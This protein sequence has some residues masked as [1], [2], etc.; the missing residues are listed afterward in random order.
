LTHYDPLASTQSEVHTGI[1]HGEGKATERLCACGC[2]RYARVGEYNSDCRTECRCGCGGRARYAYAPGHNPQID[3][4]RCGKKFTPRGTKHEQKCSQC[5]R[6]VRSGGPKERNSRLAHNREQQ[7]KAPEGKRW[8]AGCERY[9]AIKFFGQ[10]REKGVQKRYSRC[11]P[12]FREQGRASML[13]KKYNITAAEY[14][15]IKDFQGGKCAICQKAT[16]ASR[17]LAVD[18][19]HSCC[20]S[21]GSCGKC[22]RGTLCSTCNKLLGFARDDISMFI[23]AID[24]LNYPPAKVVLRNDRT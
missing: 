18:H 13:T 1:D 15:A 21:G 24:Y 16:G 6:H 5:R 9:R 8:C 10:Y 4:I 7:A 20:P 17:S 11:K 22:V 23:R 3:C 14:E 12:C 19:D 2:G